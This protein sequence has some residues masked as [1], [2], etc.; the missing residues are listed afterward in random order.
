MRL[1]IKLL[2]DLEGRSTMKRNKYNLATD[3]ALFRG[4]G[5]LEQKQD[6]WLATLS[7]FTSLGH[8]I[9]HKLKSCFARQ[10]ADNYN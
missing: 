7:R 4:H 6:L 5:W 1:K 3:K 10:T 8:N 9:R 2:G